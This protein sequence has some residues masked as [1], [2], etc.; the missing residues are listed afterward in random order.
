MRRIREPCAAA[1]QSGAESRSINKVKFRKSF[2]NALRS[3]AE[4]TYAN[5]LMMI[6][7]AQI[8]RMRCAAAKN[9]CN[10]LPL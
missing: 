5:Q 7:Y 1:A 4:F 9:L 3:G 2:A 6:K 8:S 10:P